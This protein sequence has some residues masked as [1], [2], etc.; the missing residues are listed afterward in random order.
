MMQVATVYFG[1]KFEKIVSD[2][3]RLVDDEKEAWSISYIL[4]WI[5]GSNKD[6]RLTNNDNSSSIIRLSNLIKVLRNL[7]CTVIWSGI[8]FIEI[9]SIVYPLPETYR[10]KDLYDVCNN[11]LS[12]AFF[13]LLLLYAHCLMYEETLKYSKHVKIGAEKKEKHEKAAYKMDMKNDSFIVNDT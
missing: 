13:S 8:L 3:F 5:K 9:I 12:M 2:G 4:N 11:L 1:Y 6:R 10:Y 7:I